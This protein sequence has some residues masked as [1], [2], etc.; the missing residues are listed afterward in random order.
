MLDQAQG[1]GAGN[2]DFVEFCAAG[3]PAR[4]VYHCTDCGYGV[5]VYRSLPTCP[6][7][8]GVDW[9]RAPWRPYTRTYAQV[10]GE[11]H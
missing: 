2:G 1:E 3:S 5:T 4:G 9:E 6:M 7:C 8:Q 10:S 11:A